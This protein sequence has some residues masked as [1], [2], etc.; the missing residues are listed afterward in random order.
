[1]PHTPRNTENIRKLFFLFVFIPVKAKPCILPFCLT[2]LYF[3][4]VF[5]L[6]ES[7]NGLRPGGLDSFDPL[8]KGLVMKGLPRIESQPPTQITKLPLVDP[9]TMNQK[10]QVDGHFSGVGEFGFFLI[11]IDDVMLKGFSK[12]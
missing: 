5:V 2:L 7:S 3:S 11:G 9:S 4:L 1:M 6:L 10:K 12:F 8:M